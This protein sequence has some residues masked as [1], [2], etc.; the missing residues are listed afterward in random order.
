MSHMALCGHTFMWNCPINGGVSSTIDGEFIQQV[1]VFVCVC[2]CLCV[3]FCVCMYRFCCFEI[4][5]VVLVISEYV[6]CWIS[7]V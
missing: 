1:C 7:K 6:L 2:L 5:S 3:C 4:A